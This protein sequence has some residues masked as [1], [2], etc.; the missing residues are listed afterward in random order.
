VWAGTLIVL[1]AAAYC[2]RMRWLGVAA[3]LAALLLRELALPY[4]VVAGSVAFYHGRKREAMVWAAGVVAFALI[5]FWHALQVTARLTPEDE[6]IFSE[7]WLRLGGPMFVL[8]TSRMNRYLFDAPAWLD[9]LV[10]GLSLFGL[11]ARPGED[12][13]RMRLTAVAY[14]LAFSVVGNPRINDYWGLLY[15]GLLP[16]GL[17]RV[18]VALRDLI[19]SA[20]AAPEPTGVVEHPPGEESH[21]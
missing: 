8:L 10:L 18:P 17:V 9:G 15:V 3:G 4:V 13:T 5:L 19:R 2:A 12:G 16:F 11:V 20:F 1:S 6:K 14:M 7:G 21:A